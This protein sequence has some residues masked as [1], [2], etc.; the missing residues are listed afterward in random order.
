MA[1]V[2]VFFSMNGILAAS[3]TAAVLVGTPWPM[4]LLMT[5]FITASAATVALK[6]G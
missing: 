2:F 3:A 5:L 4:I 6:R 1:M